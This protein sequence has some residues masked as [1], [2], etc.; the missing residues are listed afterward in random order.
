MIRNDDLNRH[1]EAVD[2]ITPAVEPGL[3]VEFAPTSTSNWTGIIRVA[4]VEKSIIITR[5]I[6][7]EESSDG[8]HQQQR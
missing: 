6:H 8:E 7:R 1:G 3:L 2:M 5:Y 4:V